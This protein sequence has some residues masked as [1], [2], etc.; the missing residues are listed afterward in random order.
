[1]AGDVIGTLDRAGTTVGASGASRLGLLPQIGVPHKDEG[2]QISIL[3]RKG[4]LGLS[5]KIMPRCPNFWYNFC[6]V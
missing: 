6:V 3:Q 1:M 2:Q 5:R 4:K